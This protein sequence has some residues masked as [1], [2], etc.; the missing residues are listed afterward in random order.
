MEDKKT[1]TITVNGMS[2]NVSGMGSEEHIQKVAKYLNDINEEY[3]SSVSF[4]N[5][6]FDKRGLL[7]QLNIADD[8]FRAL[9]ELTALK[10]EVELKNQEIYDI[11]HELITEQMKAENSSKSLKELSEKITN[12]ENKL[13]NK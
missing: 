8:Y 6:P 7:I 2:F 9:E 10:E 5:L 3:K 11:K 1:T 4:K 12:L 13:N